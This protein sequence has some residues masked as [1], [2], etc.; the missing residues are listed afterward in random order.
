MLHK[1]KAIV[2]HHVNYGESSI[3]VTLYTKDQGRITCMV[4][5]VRSRKPKFPATLF[6]PLTM[7]E[8]DYYYRQNRDI[9]RIKEVNCSFY[10]LT[11]PYNFSK[12]AIAL[13]LAEVLYLVLREEESNPYLFDFLNLALQIL[14]TNET[15]I[16]TYHH[17]FMI[18]LSRYLGFFP[19]DYVTDQT[20]S[21]MQA[22]TG[23]NASMQNSLLKLVHSSEAIPVLSLTHS[24]RNQLLERIIRHFSLHVDGFSR[25]RSY[26]V[27]QEVF[28]IRGQ[29][30]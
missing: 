8:L 28:D 19:S 22:F 29:K 9:H 14:D 20:G 17:W 25:L 18:Q 12:N 1:T 21:E 24:E 4:N 23:M 3:I 27:L 26:S 15:N 6:Q 30:N 11:V 7:L 13:F 5:S 10:Y 16:A 2:L